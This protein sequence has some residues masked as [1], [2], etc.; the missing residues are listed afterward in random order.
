MKLHSS[1]EVRGKLLLVVVSGEWSFNETWDLL[2][3][4]YDA[5]LEKRLNLIL[6]DAL[7]AE[8]KL[9]TFDR[10]KLGTETVEYLRSRQMNPRIA[11]VGKPPAAD[12]FAVLVAKNRWVAAEMFSNRQEALDWLGLGNTEP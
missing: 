9:T 12:G 8:G 2:K 5:A 4:T 7:A 6:I 1:M 3:Q 10:Y 11:V